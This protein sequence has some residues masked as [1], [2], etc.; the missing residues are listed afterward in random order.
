M[1][2]PSASGPGV[3]GDVH[4]AKSP[5]STLHSN[6]AGRVAENV[7]GGPPGASVVSGGVVSY[8]ARVAGVGSTLP[9]ASRARTANVCR[10][11]G[12]VTGD[13]QALNA[14]PS[15][16]HSNVPGLARGER[17]RRP[18]VRPGSS[19]AAI[20]STVKVCSAGEGSTLPAGSFAR[21][22]NVCA[23]SVNVRASGDVQAAYAPSSTLHS[24]VAVGSSEVNTNGDGPDTIVVSGAA[25]STGVP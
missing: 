22:K 5:S 10:P 18:T 24:N 17:E 11:S 25:V 6:V 2:S 19:P 12:G 13:V 14:P 15:T 4:A 20:A 9:A 1:C 3:Y 16:A 21:T 23:P 7:N 8:V